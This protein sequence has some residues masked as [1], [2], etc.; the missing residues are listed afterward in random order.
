MKTRIW[1]LIAIAVGLMA[2]SAC[3]STAAQATTAPSG[4]RTSALIVEGRLLPLETLDQSFTTGGQIAEVLV[5]E[6]EQVSAGQVLARL[7]VSPEA[8]AAWSRANLEVLAATQALDAL[9]N[10]AAVNL[11]LATVAWYTAQAKLDQAMNAYD[12]E[13]SPANLA[14]IDNAK[15]VLAQAESKLKT[16]R[17]NTGI[18]PDALIMAQAR[19]TAAEAG[20]AS[21]QA[22]LDGYSLNASMAGTV[23]GVNAL[24]G[25]RV[26]AGQVLMAVA[27]YSSWM[28][29]TTNLNENQVVKVRVGQKVTVVLDALPDKAFSG[30]VIQVSTRF[31]EKRGDITYT[32]TIAVIENDPLMRWGMTAAVQFLP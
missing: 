14:A 27:D 3:S 26:A 7:A 13:K 30:E 11:T 25:E 32:A 16:L 10:N 22:A 20:M 2:V 31:E 17:E 23:V 4:N 1:I 18:D 24:A 28:I 6:G 19:L 9:Q 8:V 12:T 29:K 5:Q 21:A 15:T